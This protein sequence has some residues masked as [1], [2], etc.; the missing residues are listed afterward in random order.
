M[1]RVLGLRS[2]GRPAALDIFI[3]FYLCWDVQHAKTFHI[4]TSLHAA[5]M[6]RVVL[7]V[8]SCATTLKGRTDITKIKHILDSKK[9]EY[10]EVDLSQLPHRRQEM[11]DASDGVITLPQLHVN[12][13]LIG[14]ADDVQEFEDWGEL[15]DLLAGVPLT[16]VVAASA[17]AAAASAAAHAD[18]L[19]AAQAALDAA[20]VAEE[21]ATEAECSPPPSPP[22][23]FAAEEEAAE[24]EAAPLEPP[25]TVVEEPEATAPAPEDTAALEEP[26]DVPPVDEDSFL[27]A[28]GGEDDE[29]LEEDEA[30]EE[31]ED[32]LED[33][34]EGETDDQLEQSSPQ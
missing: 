19:D 23:T 3:L 7:W 10:E 12:G 32:A 6:S 30:E 20:A 26:E 22:P 21:T 17:A 1:L 4:N 11:L 25:A 28:D 34:G 9:T 27:T 2:P 13:Q 29:A 14:S 8:S 18:E 31:D 24:E 15:N 33:A 16:E 5:R